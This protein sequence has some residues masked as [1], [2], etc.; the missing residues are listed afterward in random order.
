MMKNDNQP[1]LNRREF[2]RG[3]SFSTLMMLMGGVALKA[4]DKPTDA[5]APTQY[6]TTSP[7]VKCAL[8]GC[9]AWGREILKTLAVLP[10]A[11]VVGICD[12]YEPSLRRAQSSAPT[13]TPY[14]DYKKLL[15]QKDVEAVIVATPSHLHREI[16]VAAL[17]AGKHVYCEAPLA[18][19][20]EDARAI[21]KAAQA[22]VKLNFQTGLQTRSEPQRHFLLGFIRS[23]AIGKTIK[24]RAQWHKKQSWRYTSPNPDR[25]KDINW[26]LSNATSSGLVGEIGIHQVDAASWF[27]N[28]HPV[29]VTGF[30]G[31]MHW[32]E[33]GRQVPDTI[34]AVFE[35]PGGVRLSYEST[36]VNSFDAEYE[37][38]YGTESAIM[39]RDNKA[40][41]FKEVDAPMMG[42][43]VY[44][45]KDV[46]YKEAGITLVANATKSTKPAEKTG[47][48]AAYADSSLRFALGA[49]VKNSYVHKGGVEDF[50]ANFDV[51]DTEALR[52]YLASLTKAKAPAAGYKEGFEAAVTVIKA[53]EA[54]LKGQKITFAKEWFELS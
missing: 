5:D 6:K 47:D 7:P 13:A 30:G 15:E 36:L 1:D 17:R 29:S 27:I 31:V 14:Q 18:S 53:N 28:A 39:V 25:E 16:V 38:Y 26:R 10:N 52:E 23:G 43:E 20:L 42:W 21:A 41:M 4:E 35:Y 9:G 34:E 12:G 24:A 45:K 46:F 48:E 44:A 19:S 33:D 49:F 11:P 3:G 51:N 54:I 2:L 22:A 32:T 8:I 37:I 50:S 40:W